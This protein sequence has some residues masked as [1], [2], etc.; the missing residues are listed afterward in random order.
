MTQ[1]SNQLCTQHFW[2]PCSSQVNLRRINLK[3]VTVAFDSTDPYGEPQITAKC[4][5]TGLQHVG[6]RGIE[7]VRTEQVPTTALSDARPI[8]F[9][10]R[11]YVASSSPCAVED[12]R[13]LHSNSDSCS[14][15]M[16]ST[17]ILSRMAKTKA[18]WVENQKHPGP[19]NS[20]ERKSP[21]LC[22]GKPLGHAS[23]TPYMKKKLSSDRG[24]KGVRDGKRIDLLPISKYLAQYRDEKRSLYK[25][26]RLPLVRISSYHAMCCCEDDTG[27]SDCSNKEKHEL[28]QIITFFATKDVF[29]PF[30]ARS[31]P[32]RGETL[33]MEPLQ[34][35]LKA[36]T[37][38]DIKLPT[39]SGSVN[40][41]TNGVNNAFVTEISKHSKMRRSRFGKNA[42]LAFPLIANL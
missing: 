39:L 31:L 2:R 27:Y 25:D 41:S 36:K 32:T 13:S 24:T 29:K 33:Y 6:T 8:A 7:A 34:D 35:K 18:S 26:T 3:T 37:E 15:R 20:P 40:Y 1:K 28:K 12:T 16:L 10:H 17:N 30:R 42:T 19:E 14:E 4:S 9:L 11:D 5:C 23:L 21:I 38:Y 22:K